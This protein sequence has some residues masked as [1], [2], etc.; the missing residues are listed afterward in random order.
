MIRP[1]TMPAKV[2][3]VERNIALLKFV[4]LHT[5]AIKKRWE[6]DTRRA[7][8]SLTRRTRVKPVSDKRREINLVY[9]RAVRQWRAF[10]TKLDGFQCQYVY[11]SGRR[12]QKK[13]HK[14]PHHIKRRGPYLC[15]LRWFM[16][17]CL[18]HHDHIE[19]HG[20]ESERKGYIVREYQRHDGAK[21]ELPE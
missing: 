6:T 18:P 19:K 17:T 7:F 11:D 21:K 3:K 10:R 1:R 20:K 15:D 14:R 8:S 13:A 2:K 12:C 5:A 9:E 4:S 16:A